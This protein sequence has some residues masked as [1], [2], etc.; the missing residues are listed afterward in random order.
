MMCFTENLGGFFPRFFAFWC[1]IAVFGLWITCNNLAL[2][3]GKLQ[4]PADFDFET[5][6]AFTNQGRLGVL[7][8]M[9]GDPAL[10]ASRLQMD[11]R[12]ETQGVFRGKFM[13]CNHTE[14]K[15]DYGVFAL[16]D[17]RQQ[18][19]E[20]NERI[21]DSHRIFLSQGACQTYPLVV[22]TTGAGTHDF[23][24]VGIRYQSGENK[25][26]DPSPDLDLISHRATLR[27]GEAGFPE[28]LLF[29]RVKSS[30]LQSS[31]EDIQLLCVASPFHSSESKATE[32]PR[33]YVKVANPH[34]HALKVALVFFADETQ[35]QAVSPTSAKQGLFFTLSPNKST[36][37]EIDPA[38]LELNEQLWA[39]MIENPHTVLEPKRGVMVQRPIDIKKS[40]VL[41]KK[42]CFLPTLGTQ[43]SETKK[44]NL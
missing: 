8:A 4:G 38:L 11:Y 21:A 23:I 16:I 10:G 44:G 6:G 5:I 17:Y 20:L 12:L 25:I 24:F 3:Q 27:N 30:D 7:T 31:N 36:K 19:F 18:S 41:N 15:L 22:P 14:D 37:I 40:N 9:L 29:D 34:A 28:E 35:I 2:A 13:V 32:R 33:I 42:A 43:E 26:M 1:Q 39:L